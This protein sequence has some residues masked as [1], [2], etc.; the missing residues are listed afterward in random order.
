MHLTFASAQPA[1]AW[2]EFSANVSR[3][4]PNL[5]FETLAVRGNGSWDIP[6][7]I[8]DSTIV[9]GHIE[10]GVNMVLDF[11]YGAPMWGTI[12]VRITSP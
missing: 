3:N 7:T 6:F 5:L 12:A 9:A 10:W 4:G 11:A 1:S 2:L 8:P